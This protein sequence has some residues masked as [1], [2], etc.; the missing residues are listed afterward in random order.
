MEAILQLDGAKTVRQIT[1]ME[2]PS[3]LPSSTVSQ[4]TTDD[5]TES[6]IS[7]SS[8]INVVQSQSASV[9]VNSEDGSKSN[10]HRRGQVL[11]VSSP[12]LD[13]LA[14]QTAGLANKPTVGGVANGSNGNKTEKSAISPEE[15]LSMKALLSKQLVESM[16]SMVAEVSLL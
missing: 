5:R 14:S 15:I 7:E 13:M 3:S 9:S 4:T 11:P 8:H 12:D 1:S 16:I 6:N 2:K 10:N